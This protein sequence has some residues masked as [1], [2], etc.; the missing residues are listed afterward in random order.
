MLSLATFRELGVQGEGAHPISIV[1]KHGL[2]SPDLRSGVH[3]VP[4]G[5]PTT[6]HEAAAHP[7]SASQLLWTE[8]DGNQSSGTGTAGK[9]TS[10]VFEESAPYSNPNPDPKMLP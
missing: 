9:G 8:R 4:G 1:F 2:R 3:Q 5:S 10:T 6:N 7:P